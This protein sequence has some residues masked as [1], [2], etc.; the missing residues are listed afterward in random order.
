MNC[1]IRGMSASLVLLVALAGC[2]TAGQPSSSLRPSASSL[3][4]QGLASAAPSSAASTEAPTPS[5]TLAWYA[6]GT[7][8]S[9]EIKGVVGFAGGYVAIGWRRTVWFSAD[10]VTWQAVALPFTVSTDRYG[11]SLDADVQGIT[12]NGRQVLVVGGY[13]HEPCVAPGAV[14]TGG[15]PLC[16]LAPLAWVSADGRTWRSAYPGPRPADPPGYS[17]GSEFVAA[18]PVPTGGWDAA[19]SYWSGESLHGRDLWHS[20]DGITWAALAPAPALAT[21]N[22]DAFPWV[23]AGVADATGRRIL[24]QGWSDFTEPFPS[25]AGRPVMTLA[26]SLDGRSWSIIDGFPGRDAE[27]GTG[28][29]PMSGRSTRW[30]LAGAS[31]FVD[32]FTSTPTVWSSDDFVHWTATP[33]RTESGSLV[34]SVSSVILA[35]SGYVAV[36]AVWDAAQADHETWVSDD[37]LTWVA[38]RRSGA[39]GSSFG[40]GIVAA[41]PA[42][43]IGIGPSPTDGEHTSGVWQLR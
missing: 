28:V 37:G 2:A 5:S 33:L 15:G 7:I 31:N 18:W 4:S 26:T 29:A 20:V 32:D 22:A 25:G 6:H 19:L 8:P 27:V 9:A 3:A 42:G 17:Q 23:H 40:P 21:A 10:G 24:W 43:V 30:V 38:L 39:P 34:R 12:T 41:G 11:R 1:Q 16:Q 13:S 36:G 14:T 35:S